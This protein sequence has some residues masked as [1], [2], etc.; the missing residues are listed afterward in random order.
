[1]L[2]EFVRPVINQDHSKWMENHT[3]R[4]ITL[5]TW[6]SRVRIAKIILLRSVRIAIGA[7]T[8]RAT[9]RNSLIRFIKK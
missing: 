9:E 1:M 2:K 4:F 7:A 8:T 5:D 3:L 6:H